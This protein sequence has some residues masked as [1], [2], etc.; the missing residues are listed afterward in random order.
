[1]RRQTR[2]MADMLSAIPT[3]FSPETLFDACQWQ[4]G[5]AG[6]AIHH[7]RTTLCQQQPRLDRLFRPARFGPSAPWAHLFANTPIWANIMQAIRIVASKPC[8]R[9]CTLL[10]AAELTNHQY[11]L[12]LADY[13]RPLANPSH[14]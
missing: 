4:S 7:S 3:P 10:Y 9:I 2:I 14:V 11:S 8:I 12:K 5:E 6:R 1:M 13:A